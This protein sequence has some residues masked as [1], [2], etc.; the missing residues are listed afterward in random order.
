MGGTVEVRFG[1][2]LTQWGA[3]TRGGAAFAR[4]KAVSFFPQGAG[5]GTVAGR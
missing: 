5:N 3:D 1:S 2:Y 4:S